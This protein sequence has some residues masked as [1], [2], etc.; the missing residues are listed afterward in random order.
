MRF[1]ALEFVR[2]PLRIAAEAPCKNNFLP[3][4]SLRQ[5]PSTHFGSKQ[6][7]VFRNSKFASSFLIGE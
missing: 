4:G 5:A 6:N 1:A 3:N 2:F 7:V